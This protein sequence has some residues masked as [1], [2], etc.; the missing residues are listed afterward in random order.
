[1]NFDNYSQSLL[2]P[3]IKGNGLDAAGS[4]AIRNSHKGRHKKIKTQNTLSR[5]FQIKC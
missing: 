5:M 2:Y 4:E 1:M 3:E